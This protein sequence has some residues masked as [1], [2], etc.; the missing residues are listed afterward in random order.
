[1]LTTVFAGAFYA[2]QWITRYSL[3][4]EMAVC[5]AMTLVDPVVSLILGLLFWLFLSVSHGFIGIGV[6]PLTLGNS[7]WFV[8]PVIPYFLGAVWARKQAQAVRAI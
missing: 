7:A 2:G 3:G 4:R 1:M 8:F 6:A 5:F